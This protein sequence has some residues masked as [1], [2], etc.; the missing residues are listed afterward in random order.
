VIADTTFHGTLNRV[1]KI[2]GGGVLGSHYAKYFN[3]MWQA[4]FAKGS[5]KPG[6]FA[7]HL[8]TSARPAPAALAD[9]KGGKGR[10]RAVRRL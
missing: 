1:N 7:I 10:G 2:K 8:L 6:P 3:F 9:V 4:T 5:G